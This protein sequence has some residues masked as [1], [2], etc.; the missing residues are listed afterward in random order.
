MMHR[1]DQRKARNHQVNVLAP[2]FIATAMT[3]RDE[4]DRTR[5]VSPLYAAPDAVVVDTTGKTIEEVVGAVLR[6]VE[7]FENLR[8]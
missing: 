4:L 1:G 5:P 6:L 3:A 7:T 2:G 8:T